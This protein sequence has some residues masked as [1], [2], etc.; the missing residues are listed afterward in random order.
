MP[1]SSLEQV[2][3]ESSDGRGLAVANA[4]EAYFWF[5]AKSRIYLLAFYAKND[6]SDLSAEEKRVLRK[7]VE[8]D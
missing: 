5:T 1:N 6:Q 4:A 2:V 8:D 7:V 3:S